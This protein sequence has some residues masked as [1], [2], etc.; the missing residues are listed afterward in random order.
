[1]LLVDTRQGII[2]SCLIPTILA[3]AH[4][5]LAMSDFGDFFDLLVQSSLYP[6]TPK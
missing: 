2:C 1:M 4:A 6:D 3:I 5:I